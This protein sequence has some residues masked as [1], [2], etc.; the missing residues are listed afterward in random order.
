[1]GKMRKGGK[2]FL[3]FA[4]G[5]ALVFL[6]LAVGL[7]F[8][9]SSH[10]G[11]AF[12]V[13]AK[14][15][16][17][18]TGLA[19]A[20]TDLTLSRQGGL[21]FA[22]AGK[23][24]NAIDI[25]SGRSV[26][27]ATS[28]SVAVKLFPSLSRTVLVEDLQIESPKASLCLKGDGALYAG[29]FS[30]GSIGALEAKKHF[31]SVS[32]DNVLIRDAALSLSFPGTFLP[33][34]SLSGASLSRNA[35][36]GSFALDGALAWG[37]VPGNLEA[38]A[39]LEDGNWFFQYALTGF[40]LAGIA[41]P[42]QGRNHGDMRLEG[43]VSFSGGLNF[44]GQG[45]ASWQGSFSLEQAALQKER[46]PDNIIRAGAFSGRFS[47]QA[48]PGESLAA[49]IHID[50]LELPA[51]AV[52]GAASYTWTSADGPVFAARGKAKALSY[53]ELKPY[54]SSFFSKKAG[55][56]LNERLIGG[57]TQDVDLYFGWSPKRGDSGGFEMDL[58]TKAS[59]VTLDLNNSLGPISGI[60]ATLRFYEDHMTAEE[61]SAKALAGPVTEGHFWL[62]YSPGSGTPALVEV[63]AKADSGNAWPQTLG[64][65]KKPPDWVSRLK[66]SG[67][68]DVAVRWENP[69]L[70]IQG[71][72]RFEVM[73]IPVGMALRY[74]HP[75]APLAAK[76][77]TGTVVVD[78]TGITFDRLN[79]E[80]ESIRA[81]LK[82]RAHF[83]QEQRVSL[84]ADLSGLE[85]LLPYHADPFHPLR[86]W[87]PKKLSGT[88]DAMR[89]PGAA[90]PLNL[91]LSLTDARGQKLTATAAIHE[92]TWRFGEVSGAAGDLRIKAVGGPKT[93]SGSWDILLGDAKNPSYRLSLVWEKEQA[94]AAFWAHQALLHDWADWRIPPLWDKLFAFAG[95]HAGEYAPQAWP[96]YG[97]DFSVDM[98][99]LGHAPALAG[100]VHLTGRA[101]WR[102]GFTAVVSQASWG[103]IRGRASYRG[104]MEKGLLEI[105]TDR[106][107]L[108]F[109]AALLRAGRQRPDASFCPPEQ[110]RPPGPF[111][112]N[113]FSELTASINVGLL[114]SG[115]YERPFTGTVRYKKNEGGLT[116]D[117]S[118]EWG[119]QDLALAVRREGS[120][121]FVG[122]NSSL[123][124][125]EPI[126][127]ALISE[128]GESPVPSCPASL[129]QLS[130]EADIGEL[131]VGS[132]IS[133]PFEG[134]AFVSPPNP[135]NPF[136]TR[137]TV[138]H[139]RFLEQEGS[140]VLAWGGDAGPLVQLKF[141]SFTFQA[142]L[143][144]FRKSKKQH[145][146]G[147]SRPNLGQK[148]LLFVL[149][150]PG[151]GILPGETQALYIEGSLRS[152]PSRGFLLDAKRFLWGEQAGVFSLSA[153]S[154]A[155]RLKGDFAFLDMEKWK[156]L[157][158]FVRHGKTNPPPAEETKGRRLQIALPFTRMDVDLEIKADR[159]K[160]LKTQFESLYLS[161]RSS[162]GDAAV[163]ELSW[164]KGGEQVF[165]LSGKLEKASSGRW[166]GGARAWFE[167]LGDVTGLLASGSQGEGGRFPIEGGRT[168]LRMEGEFVQNAA[169]LYEPK[170]VLS[171]SS[172]EG[173]IGRQKGLLLLLG[174]LSPDNY[175]RLLA[176][177]RTDLAGQGLVFEEMDSD[178]FIDGSLATVN[179]FVL[180]GPSLRY[181]ATGTVDLKSHFQ[182]LKICMQ[183]FRT[184]DSIVG[185]TP[186]LNW[187]LQGDTGAVF[188]TCFQAKGD[189]DEPRIL[190]IPKSMIPTGLRDL[191]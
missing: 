138:T 56:W 156:A 59:Q 69:G 171:F 49:S 111:E 36:E 41:V 151:A 9:M 173:R 153:T 47:G 188:E 163:D 32:W 143:D 175:L 28:F 128:N 183:P 169:G 170:G 164:K 34:A 50:E 6:G 4:T 160:F 11:A 99:R 1:M 100:A 114:A 29:P 51:T 80:W 161:G 73:V 15:F 126:L 118:L 106:M 189:L 105:W 136:Y 101:D 125:A 83:D 117:S 124:R 121:A 92:K 17:R 43:F 46:V 58:A 33:E 48:A 77:L 5:L 115:G 93:P 24:L 39:F 60:N 147:F 82:G 75:D 137:M 31:I 187:I 113:A 37:D 42:G 81:R 186:G 79:L 133:S 123:L 130:L 96:F 44:S 109:L 89:E 27:T 159:L 87:S 65:M 172:R 88:I 52:S 110:A 8:W 139:F 190:P 122:I 107:E 162:P 148:P 90:K 150:A 155:L 178:I 30:L 35:Q 176:G 95:T 57:H 86:I 66:F 67:P 61:L 182:D 97:M 3:I 154:K 108:E 119:D 152:G 145:T 68:A 179:S 168:S 166:Q 14:A 98:N 191:F 26:A 134:R 132:G 165:Q 18:S 10:P 116:L 135:E 181:L 2:K 72:D 71:P 129:S 174:A 53:D 20:A 74:E 104:G 127:M 22:L 7:F 19:A 146:A 63:K 45:L 23:N 70:D 84:S 13:A 76:G 149:D 62:E 158:S 140:G 25:A 94:K 54:L 180:K 142:M 167:E 55:I 184:L 185:M 21:R 120:R 157:H 91:A 16:E 141:S 177:Q 102:K 78:D 85:T 131:Y 64:L 40:S 112:P 12:S 144:A 103:E 38:Q